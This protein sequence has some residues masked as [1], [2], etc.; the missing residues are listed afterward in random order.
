VPSNEVLC[1]S[2]CFGR[3]HCCLCSIPHRQHSFQCPKLCT[4]SHNLH[5]RHSTNFLYILPANQLN[6]QPIVT[7]P[8]MSTNSLMYNINIPP[9]TN[10]VLS[11]HDNTG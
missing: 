7:F 5:R 8:P 10:V 3:S 11:L 2:R 4:P 6:A 9:G 1:L